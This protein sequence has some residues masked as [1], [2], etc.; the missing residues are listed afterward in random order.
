[1]QKLMARGHIS[2]VA[3]TAPVTALLLDGD[4]NILCIGTGG[5]LLVYTGIGLDNDGVDSLR[6]GPVDLFDTHTIH[7]IKVAGKTR[8]R[9]VV[10]GGKAVCVATMIAR[11]ANG[12]DYHDLEVNANMQNL[13]DLVLD[14]TVVDDLLLI[15]FAHNFIDIMSEDNGGK[16]VRT[17]RVQCADIS[18]LFSLSIVTASMG[19]SIKDCSNILVGSGTAFG[20]II[21]WNFD[22]IKNGELIAELS[23]TVKASDILIGHEGV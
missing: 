4:R 19:V 16:Y 14:C 23:P 13:D 11:D 1:M 7:G 15:G 21:L 12:S 18:A 5:Q 3:I 20:K 10:Y 8:A 9:V 17:C 6:I 22:A 2:R